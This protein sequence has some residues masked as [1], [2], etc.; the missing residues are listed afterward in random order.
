MNQIVE[1][2]IQL[3]EWLMRLNKENYEETLLKIKNSIFL[4]KDYLLTLVL[5]TVGYAASYFKEIPTFV[6]LIIELNNANSSIKKKVLKYNKDIHPRIL[7]HLYKAGFLNIDEVGKFGLSYSKKFYFPFL[8]RFNDKILEEADSTLFQIYDKNRD[9]WEQVSLVGCFD[10]SLEYALYQD[11]VE[12]LAKFASKEGFD[13]D[14][15]IP[16]RIISPTRY[17]DLTLKILDIASLYG[18]AKCFRFLLQNGSKFTK[19]ASGTAIIGQSLDIIKILEANDFNFGAKVMVDDYDV[20]PLS[21]AIVYHRKDL[22]HWIVEDR[23]QDKAK[24][25]SDPTLVDSVTKTNNYWAL[26][27]IMQYSTLPFYGLDQPLIFGNTVAR[28]HYYMMQV[29]Y[30]ICPDS[31]KNDNLVISNSPLTWSIVKQHRPSFQFLIEKGFDPNQIAVQLTPIQHAASLGLEKYVDLLIP[32]CDIQ[33]RSDENATVL[34]YAAI[35]GNNNIIKKLLDMNLF[36]PNEAVVV[37]PIIPNKDIELEHI[38]PP[39]KSASTPYRLAVM[40]G[41][42]ETVKFLEQID[43]I[44]A[45]VTLEDFTKIANKYIYIW[46]PENIKPMLEHF[47][48]KIGFSPDLLSKE[49]RD[50]D[51]LRSPYD[52]TLSP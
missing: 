15:E 21:V 13:F 14:G 16:D 23:V 25:L 2:I 26:A 7:F 40:R 20:S 22:F 4:Q 50:E 39:I 42:I 11:N 3:Q 9:R 24:V 17:T 12:E 31:S 43:G 47:K 41:N 32:I 38:V 37:Q 51:Y 6:K 1:P 27:A 18:S 30:K 33:K 52:L 10:D 48:E 19:C 44:K 28:M 49:V 34:H 29:I 8:K 45:E 35:G 36:D 46:V 5:N